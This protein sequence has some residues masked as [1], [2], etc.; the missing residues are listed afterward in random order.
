MHYVDF[1]HQITEKYGIV[2]ECWPLKSFVSPGDL[3]TLNE[4]QI[5]HRAWESGTTRFRKMDKKELDVW[6]E[7]RFQATLRSG[8][9]N[10][11]MMD[12][13]EGE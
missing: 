9:Q 1:D 2:V 10:G 4:L 5:L 13:N 6:E 11:E 7:A 8:V 3:R 12:D